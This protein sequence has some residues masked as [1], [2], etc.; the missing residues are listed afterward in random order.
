MPTIICSWCQYVGQGEELEDR[1]SDALVH[2]LKE[3]KEEFIELHGQEWYDYY[4]EEF[5]EDL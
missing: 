1:Q 5:K 4:I 3:H 2:E